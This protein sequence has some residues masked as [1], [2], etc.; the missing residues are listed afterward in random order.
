MMMALRHPNKRMGVQFLSSDE[1]VVFPARLLGGPTRLPRSWIGNLVPSRS[2]A[3]RK[4][5]HIYRRRS[6]FSMLFS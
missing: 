2:A 4:R 6:L 3:Q 5:R 1:F